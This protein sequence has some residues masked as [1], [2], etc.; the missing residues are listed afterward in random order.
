MRGRKYAGKDPQIEVRKD[1]FGNCLDSIIE[2]DCLVL[3]V[4]KEVSYGDI[5]VREER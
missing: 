5:W 4:D 2:K 1:E 3:S